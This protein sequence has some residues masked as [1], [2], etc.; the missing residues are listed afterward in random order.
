M[1]SLPSGSLPNTFA[2]TQ[3]HLCLTCITILHSSLKSG[4]Q[5][6]HFYFYLY[7]FISGSWGSLKLCSICNYM[8]STERHVSL[9]WRNI[10]TYGN[11]EYQFLSVSMTCNRVLAFQMNSFT[12]S[13]LHSKSTWF[14]SK[15]AFSWPWFLSPQNTI[16]S[17]E[18]SIWDLYILFSVFLT[19]LP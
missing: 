4:M 1:S 16:I 11:D 8:N 13:K 6:F 10:S 5:N 9:S 2:A 7:F 18:V 12:F 3:V 15:I 14:C 19:T 17:N